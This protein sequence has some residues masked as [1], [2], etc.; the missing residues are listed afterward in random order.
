M[1]KG[2]MKFYLNSVANTLPTGN[3]LLQWGKSTTDLCKLCK[4]RETTCHV[5]N[6]CKVA[7]DQGKYTWRHDNILNFTAS[8]LDKIKFRFYIDLEDKK[9][10]T[11]GTIPVDLYIT[12]QRPDIVIIND[13]KKTCDIFEL[14]CP[15]EPNIVTRNREKTEKYA[16]F[17]SKI[18]ELKTAVTCFE[19]GSRG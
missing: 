16:H 5:L 2:T 19:F 3:N 4:C 17:Q 13:K 1:K 12:N 6:N 8:C 7:L 9:T 14:T 18:E 15:L 11:G 10:E